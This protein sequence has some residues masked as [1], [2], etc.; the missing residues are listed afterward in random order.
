[1]K[2]LRSAHVTLPANVTFHNRQCSFDV[3]LRRSWL[4]VL[5]EHWKY[6]DMNQTFVFFCVARSRQLVRINFIVNLGPHL[7]RDQGVQIHFHIPHP[8][9]ISWAW[10][11]FNNQQPLPYSYCDSR[12][13][14]CRFWS[15]PTLRCCKAED[16]ERI[17]ASANDGSLFRC[18]YFL[19]TD[20]V[21][22]HS[23]ITFINK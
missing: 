1:M 19:V 10:F 7:A 2:V 4:R 22:K 6:Q 12:A 11:S 21:S 5:D 3:D 18:K 23:L 15:H 17:V 8:V 14:H 16:T 9:D 20:K 13:T